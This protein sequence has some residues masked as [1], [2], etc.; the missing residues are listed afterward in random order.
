ML[1]TDLFLT[2]R[3][4]GSRNSDRASIDL[5]SAAGDLRLTRGRANLAQAILNRL[6]TRQGELAALGHPDY[7]S[8]LYQLIGEPN[9]RRTHALADL[10]LRESLAEEERV[11]EIID[12]T[13]TP[14]SLRAE[15][16]NVLEMRITV[17]PIA[18]TDTEPGAGVSA[19]AG[20]A[21]DDE[22][23]TLS[24]AMNLEG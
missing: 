16:R 2:R 14:P 15:L 8:R 13:I 22:L 23:L 21:A 12:I 24:L 17:R 20:G 9:T 6:F 4:L 19:P 7:G 11:A 3:A 10:Y 18:A 1:L 5:G